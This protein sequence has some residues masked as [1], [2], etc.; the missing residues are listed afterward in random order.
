MKRIPQ[1]P[2]D[3][4]TQPAPQPGC[5]KMPAKEALRLRNG[6]ARLFH[7]QE[8]RRQQPATDAQLARL[9]PLWHA[10]PDD[11]SADDRIII[12]NGGLIGPNGELCEPYGQHLAKLRRRF[13]GCDFP[14]SP[15]N[16]DIARTTED[17]HKLWQDEEIRDEHVQA[18]AKLQLWAELTRYKQT[19]FDLHE[20]AVEAQ[21][22]YNTF[23]DV[24]TGR[25]AIYR[26][27]NELDRT[28]PG[29]LA[30]R[31]PRLADIATLQ[32]RY[33]AYLQ[34]RQD[35]VSLLKPLV[36]LPKLL[37]TAD[38]KP[39]RRAFGVPNPPARF[40]RHLYYARLA[41]LGKCSPEALAEFMTKDFLKLSHHQRV[42]FCDEYNRPSKGRKDYKYGFLWVWLAD[43]APLFNAF[44]ARWFD[45]FDAVSARFN[46]DAPEGYRDCPVDGEQ[47]KVLWKEFEDKHW[48]EQPRRIKPPT[49][50]RRTG[51]KCSIPADLLTPL[52]FLPPA[53]KG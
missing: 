48:P 15:A 16:T 32:E 38:L 14:L 40:S 10:L 6:V 12:L 28:Y 4:I 34:A 47:L 22:G 37:A 39:D 44:Q 50:R 31:Q 41:A 24:L 49:G 9:W 42:E 19:T 27:A 45:I 20:A 29:L 26:A 35:A 33:A 13:P 1:H 52:P 51:E 53:D 23:D 18:M 2:S 7:E 25:V 5:R 46:S 3:S 36:F 21:L 8:L 17:R 30:M 11:I 43:N